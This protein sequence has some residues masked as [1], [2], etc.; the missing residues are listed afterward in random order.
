MDQGI[1]ERLP[2]LPV[3]AASADG[4]RQAAAARLAA[5]AKAQPG[6]AFTAGGQE[7]RGAVMAKGDTARTWAEDPAD[8]R[9]R[10]LTLEEHRTFW[11][12]A[13]IEVLTFPVIGQPGAAWTRQGR[14]WLRSWGVAGPVRRGRRRDPVRP[15]RRGGAGC[16]GLR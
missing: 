16:R 7:L 1:R 14:L 3:L 8:G 11:A 12:W 6:E 5:C 10:D 4:E 15:V 2:V 9:R 13:A